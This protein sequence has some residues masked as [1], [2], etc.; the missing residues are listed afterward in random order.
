MLRAPLLTDKAPKGRYRI[1]YMA[2]RPWKFARDDLA[3]AMLREI[4]DDRYVSG[5]PMVR[6]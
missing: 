4:V 6:Y 2:L 5:A 3:D 1:G